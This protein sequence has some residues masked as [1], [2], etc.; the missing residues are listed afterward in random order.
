MT[1]LIGGSGTDKNNHKYFPNSVRIFN[2]ENLQVT[3]GSGK[4]STTKGITIS[5]EN[6][7]YVWANFN[8]TGIN[9]AP[10]DG[11]SSLNDAS[12]TY[13][14]LGNQVPSSIVCDSIFP[15]SKTFFDSETSL[16]PDNLDKRPGDNSP[17]V[18]QETSVRAAII[19]GNNLSAMTGTP[20]AGNS[21][22]DESRL[23]GGMHNFPRFLEKWTARWNFVG[24]M[25]PLYHSVQAVGQYNAN[26]TIY[27]PPTRNWAFDVTFTDPLRL[28]PGTPMFQ[29]IEPTGFKQVL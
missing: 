11:T 10:P 9:T 27:S 28:P 29:H 12:T 23:C 8:T 1:N 18:S 22:N 7:V 3:G 5:S 4:L 15:L 13:Y 19:A 24:S 2:G 20:D 25:I 17:S 6:M 14:Y 26:S 16:Y 21:A